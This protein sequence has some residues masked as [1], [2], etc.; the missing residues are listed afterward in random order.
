MLPLPPDLSIRLPRGLANQPDPTFPQLPGI[1]LEPFA[2]DLTTDAERLKD[3]PRRL[4]KGWVRLVGLAPLRRYR[5]ME[6][7]RQDSPVPLAAFA[8]CQSRESGTVRPGAIRNRSDASQVVR[9]S[10]DSGPIAVTRGY[11]VATAHQHGRATLAAPQEGARQAKD[12]E[13]RDKLSVRAGK[14]TR[15]GQDP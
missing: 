13:R 3:N 4:G 15:S 5:K 10:F 1:I 12:A 9:T 8:R 6:P 11:P 7:R 2:A 14:D